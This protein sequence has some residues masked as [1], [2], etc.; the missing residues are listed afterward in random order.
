M[1]TASLRRFPWR[2]VLKDVGKGFLQ[3]VGILPLEK[4]PK[5]AYWARKQSTGEWEL[6]YPAYT[7]D[8][9]PT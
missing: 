6:R 1:H 7:W 4:L 8:H 5:G 9:P 3:A 2:Q